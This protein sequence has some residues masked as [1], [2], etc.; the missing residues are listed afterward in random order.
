MANDIRC[1][2]CRRCVWDPVGGGFILCCYGNDLQ[3]RVH[4][5]KKKSFM[6]KE[7][8]IALQKYEEEAIPI[9][10]MEKAHRQYAGMPKVQ[11]R[12]DMF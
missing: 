8:Q 3:I 7:C 9:E 6:I 11:S 2:E 4:H 12:L 5:S 10:I 1:D